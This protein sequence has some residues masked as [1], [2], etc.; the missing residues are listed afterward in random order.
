MSKTSSSINQETIEKFNKKQAL[1]EERGTYAH[2]ALK[3]LQKKDEMG[4]SIY[5]NSSC[6]DLVYDIIESVCPEPYEELIGWMDEIEDKLP[7]S[8]PYVDIIEKCYDDELSASFIQLME[9]ADS[10][11]ESKISLD[12]LRKIIEFYDMYFLKRGQELISF[13]QAELLPK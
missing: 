5:E 1:L 10:E 11:E 3:S 2:E 12:S 7:K 8:G 13:A 9:L 6:Q 4:E